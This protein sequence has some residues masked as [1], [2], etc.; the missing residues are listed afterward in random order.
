MTAVW[1][2]KTWPRMSVICIN[3]FKLFERFYFRYV[4]MCLKSDYATVFFTVCVYLPDYQQKL[5]PDAFLESTL[6]A[7]EILNS[8]PQTCSDNNCIALSFSASMFKA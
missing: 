2:R 6:S 3:I 8:Q 4:C 5:L 1:N 7:L